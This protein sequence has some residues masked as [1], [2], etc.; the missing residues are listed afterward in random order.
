M[1]GAENKEVP[2]H[3]VFICSAKASTELCDCHQMQGLPHPFRKSVQ[4]IARQPQQSG[5]SSEHSI[6]HATAP[7]LADCSPNHEQRQSHPL[8]R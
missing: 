6:Y 7:Y 5:L 2:S 8:Q 1:T 4:L 3:P